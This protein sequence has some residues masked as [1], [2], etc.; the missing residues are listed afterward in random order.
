MS[1]GPLAKTPS[2]YL[3]TGSQM[4]DKSWMGAG[5]GFLPAASRDVC[6]PVPTID[7]YIFV[8]GLSRIFLLLGVT[9]CRLRRASGL[10]A[11]D[12]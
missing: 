4:P 11:Y 9:C 10:S 12:R 6:R 7:M 5:P 2:R 3:G 1:F 8:L